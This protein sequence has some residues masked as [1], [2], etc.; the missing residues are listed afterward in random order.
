VSPLH[1]IQ[2]PDDIPCARRNP[3]FAISAIFLLG[4]RGIAKQ[5]ALNTPPISQLGDDR[6]KAVRLST[7]L[8]DATVKMMRS[9]SVAREVFGDEF[10]DHYGGTREHEVKLWNEAVTNWEG[11]HPLQLLPLAITYVLDQWND[12]LNWLESIYLNNTACKYTH[13]R[14]EIKFYSLQ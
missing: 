9:G 10:V 1:Y 14:G 3:Y 7:S 11:K 12:T 5:T 2:H 6:S 4:L 8:E 13:D